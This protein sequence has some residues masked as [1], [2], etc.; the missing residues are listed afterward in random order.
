[1]KWFKHDATAGMDAK[2]KKLR[3]RYGLEGYGL[4]WYLLECIARTVEPT[5]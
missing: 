4:Y 5:T 3:L 2:L 1:M